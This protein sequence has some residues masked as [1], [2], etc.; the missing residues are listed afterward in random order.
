MQGYKVGLRGCLF[1]ILR[2]TSQPTSQVESRQPPWK[3]NNPQATHSPPPP[4]KTNTFSGAVSLRNGSRLWAHDT[5]T[6]WSRDPFRLRLD[7]SANDLPHPYAASASPCA[8]A[9]RTDP[10]GRRPCFPLRCSSTLVKWVLARP[11]R[12]DWTPSYQIP[13]LKNWGAHFFGEKKGGGSGGGWPP[14]IRSPSLPT[15]P[16]HS[17]SLLNLSRRDC[18]TGFDQKLRQAIQAQNGAAVET[19]VVGTW[20]LQQKRATNTLICTHWYIFL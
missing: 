16:P 17:S 8:R 15:H 20:W 10:F 3:R 14:A 12:V 11:S 7:A 18:R 6:W 5:V 13:W 4:V 9:N 19:S 2:Y 1:I